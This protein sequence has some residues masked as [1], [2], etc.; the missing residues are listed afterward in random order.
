[1]NKALFIKKVILGGGR[2]KFLRNNETD[3]ESNQAG[4]RMDNLNL[5]DEW[6][7]SKN[8]SSSFSYVTLKDELENLNTTNT[9]YLLGLF[10]PSD[11]A[12]RDQQEADNDP[13]LELMTRK[14][15]EILQKNPKGFFLLV[16]GNF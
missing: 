9:D 6:E 12:Y 10:A 7:K 14:A 13:S 1:L 8:G 11:I 15:I 5:I 4:E 3:P 2:R 16:E